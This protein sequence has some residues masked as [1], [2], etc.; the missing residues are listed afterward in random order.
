MNTPAQ[1]GRLPD[2]Y[3]IAT[4][5]RATASRSQL[6]VA[7]S[8]RQGASAKS[9]ASQGR[10]RWVRTSAATTTTA[11]TSSIAELISQ[12]HCSRLWPLPVSGVSQAAICMKSPVSTGYS[13]YCMSGEGIGSLSRYG[14]S[15]TEKPRPVN[16]CGMSL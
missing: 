4:A 1:T 7:S 16:R 15:P 13:R 2:Q 8:A 14:C 11:Q 5:V 9:S 3:A 6:T 12:N 10:R